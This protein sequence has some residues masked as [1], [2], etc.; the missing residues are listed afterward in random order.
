MC[1]KLEHKVTKGCR[2]RGAKNA[3]VGF[4]Y[5]QEFCLSCVLHYSMRSVLLIATC[6]VFFQSVNSQKVYKGRLVSALMGRPIRS[7]YIH[8]NDQIVGGTDTLG[9]FVLELDTL[10]THVPLTC[11][12]SEVGWALIDYPDPKKE[13]VPVISLMPEC[14]YSAPD[15]IAKKSIK[16]LTEIGPFNA[17]LTQKDKAFAKKYHVTYVNYG[18]NCNDPAPADCIEVYNKAIG[19]YLDNKYGKQWRKEVF[20]NVRGL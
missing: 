2:K 14:L 3:A 19:L 10:P 15:D 6:L 16:I 11:W 4:Y 9:F 8:L 1:M 5:L 12:A 7:G 20:K 18:E 13:E 17:R